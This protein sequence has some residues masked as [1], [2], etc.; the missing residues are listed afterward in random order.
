MAIEAADMLV[1]ENASS[2]TSEQV[3]IPTAATRLTF[4]NK[5]GS[6]VQYVK[7]GTTDNLTAAS[8]DIEVPASTSITFE[9]ARAGQFTKLA[10]IA[11]SGTPNYQ[12]RVDNSAGA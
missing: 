11:A 5:D 6:I 4:V 3:E 10:V 12:V 8:T 9:F 1:D 7:L 2:T